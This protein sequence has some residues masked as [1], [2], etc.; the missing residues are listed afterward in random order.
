VVPTH[1]EIEIETI[2]IEAIEIET[3]EPDM[4]I[5]TEEIQSHEN[6]PPIGR[7][8][9]LLGALLLALTLAGGV[10]ARMSVGGP[11]I[12]PPPPPPP[13][14]GLEF[15]AKGG[16]PVHFGGR[17]DRG[18]VLE[19]GD[20]LVNMELVIAGDETRALGRVRVPT[21]LV[22]ILDR[23]GSMAGPPI[24]HARAA[25]R[26][27]IGSLSED[28]RFSLITY[29]SGAELQIPLGRAT[30]QARSSWLHTLGALHVG[31]GTNMSAG[32]E[33]ATHGIDRASKRGRAMRVILLSDGHANEGDA[34]YQ[35]LVARAQRV[36]RAE[37]VLSS[38]GVGDGFDERLM[39]GLADA[40]TGNFYYVQR[41]HELGE[42]FAGEFAA[43]RANL[44]SALR[45]EIDPA[46]GIEVISAAGYPLERSGGRVAFHPG[47]LF[48]GQERR[49]WVSLRVPVDGLVA[50]DTH[51]LGAFSL[52][53]KRE[54]KRH[55]L[56]FDETPVV[57]RVQTEE[58]F[59]AAVSPD[60]WEQNV[61]EEQLGALKQTVA[62]AISSG[63]RND[64]TEAIRRFEV[65]QQ[66]LNRQIKSEKVKDAL[67]SLIGMGAEVDE[68]FAASPAVRGRVSKKYLAEGLE[69]R[70]SGAKYER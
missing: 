51:A 15:D 53:F 35:G 39:T 64:A 23:S 8:R 60:V 67:D 13:L 6:A 31:G 28:D 45:V 55:T 5:E 42:V 38:V 59:I 17:L 46:P 29:S 33:L 9:W 41:S 37:Y 58:Q 52:S 1:R 3:K 36:A 43:S 34:S 47:A 14:T 65:K 18:S 56:R 21:D 22:V 27:L 54:G 7:K 4:T 40:G 20:G 30:S 50:D 49:I 10:A 44:A 26:E 25:V 68:A 70:R 2:E 24:E 66:S 61:V 11:A 19:D 57:A 12:L 48:A 63:R 16:G 32:L 69:G 62:A